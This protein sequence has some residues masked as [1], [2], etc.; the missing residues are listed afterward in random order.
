MK[1]LVVTLFCYGCNVGPVQTA[2][3]IKGI[4][5]KQIAYLNLAH[6]REKDLIEASKLVINAFNKFELPSYWGTGTTA[7]VDGTR[8]DMYE[9]NLLSEFHVRY[10]SYGGVGY[11]LVS[12]KYIALFSRFIPCGVR[13]AMYLIDALMQNESDLAPD[14]V[15]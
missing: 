5:R 1:R 12:D 14:T 13:E 4:S 15:H 8:F 2:R 9:Q 6:T 10:A 7:S 3:S 11:Y